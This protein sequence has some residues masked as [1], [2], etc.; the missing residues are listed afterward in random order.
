MNQKIHNN[1]FLIDPLG[2]SHIYFNSWNNIILTV[3]INNFI[4]EQNINSSSYLV[5][6]CINNLVLLFKIGN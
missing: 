6:N 2:Y 1:F 3:I 4:H 5:V